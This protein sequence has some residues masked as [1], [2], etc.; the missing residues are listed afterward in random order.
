MPSLLLSWLKVRD[1]VCRPV[2][3]VDEAFV[4]AL[5]G[6]PLT[7]GILDQRVQLVKDKL[8]NEHEKLQLGPDKGLFLLRQRVVFELAAT[9]AEFTAASARCLVRALQ[10]TGA[11]SLEELVDTVGPSA[12][13]IAENLLWEGLGGSGHVNQDS[14]VTAKNGEPI[15]VLKDRF[16]LAAFKKAIDAARA[17]QAKEDAAAAAAQP[18]EADSGPD[19]PALAQAAG[20][21]AWPRSLLPT[22]AMMSA[23]A[24]ASKGERGA[25]V[26]WADPKVAPWFDQKWLEEEQRADEEH[27]RALGQSAEDW[28]FTGVSKDL[29]AQSAFAAALKAS[30]TRIRFAHWTAALTRITA[31]LAMHGALGPDGHS[32]AANYMAVLAALAAERGPDFAIDYDKDFR[33]HVAVECIPVEEAVPLFRVLDDPRAAALQRSKDDRARKPSGSGKPAQAQQ[34]PGSSSKPPGGARNRSRGR[35]RGKGQQAPQ[36]AGRDSDKRPASSAPPGAPPAKR[37]GG[38]KGGGRR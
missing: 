14:G 8:P 36:G 22:R 3:H 38:G 2:E 25:P 30:R 1:Q 32:V 12:K 29:V 19:I 28:G 33:R 6:A 7:L 18:A 16:L 21:G 31:A 10:Q 17:Q 35:N 9:E 23:L 27:L 24:K 37:E 26:P 5:G 20:Y 15:L 34:G 11:Q 13:D 4:A